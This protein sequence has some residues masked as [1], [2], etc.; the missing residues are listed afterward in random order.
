VNVDLVVVGSGLFGLTI[1][2]RCAND[3]GLKVLV[4]DRRHHVGGNAYSEAEPASS[5]A[6]L[7]TIGTAHWVTN[8]RCAAANSNWRHCM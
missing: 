2:E 1:A 6:P 4:L 7:Y 5:A 3:L 8:R